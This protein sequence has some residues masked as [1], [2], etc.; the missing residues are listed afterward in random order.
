MTGSGSRPPVFIKICGLKDLETALTCVRLGADAVGF[1]FFDKSPRY[2]PVRTARHISEHLPESTIRIGVFVDE[3]FDLI[4]KT[5]DAGRLNGVQLH[6]NEPGRL[7]TRLKNENLLVTKA[8]FAQKKPYF[9][10]AGDFDHADYFLVEYGKGT[11]PGGNAET[12]DYRTDMIRTDPIKG[13]IPVIIAGGLG[14]DTVRNVL[15]H[16]RA[17]GV[18]VSSGVESSPGIKDIQKIAAF[19]RAVRAP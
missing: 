11:L 17:F 13:E 18:D 19:I 14:P 2:I 4:M 8:L 9:S 5:V 16:T 1:V 3:P 7:V 15:R 12:W 6:G 10:Q